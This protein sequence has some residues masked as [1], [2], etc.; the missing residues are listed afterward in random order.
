[1]QMRAVVQQGQQALDLQTQMHTGEKRKRS[2]SPAA[3]RVVDE[4]EPGLRPLVQRLDAND[5]PIPELGTPA[6]MP[7]DDAAST[8]LASLAINAAAA[9]LASAAAAADGHSSA[10]HTRT[11]NDAC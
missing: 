11:C 3:M 5:G 10:A 7:F 9:E 1:M 4:A 2:D 6:A 8:Y